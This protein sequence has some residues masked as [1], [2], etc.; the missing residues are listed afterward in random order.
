MS[1]FLSD[2]I[3]C[4]SCHFRTDISDC[5]LFF[6]F[7]HMTVRIQDIHELEIYEF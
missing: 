2:N 3:F 5:G 4:I 7:A 6:G 1:I